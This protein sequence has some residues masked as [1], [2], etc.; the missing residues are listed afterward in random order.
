M[1]K[2]ITIG[3]I[4]QRTYQTF[5]QHFDFVM[6][7]AGSL[8][9]FGLLMNA[10]SSR[11]LTHAD[12]LTDLLISVI[13]SMLFYAKVA[14]MM[15]RLVILNESAYSGFWRWSGIELRF[16]AWLLLVVALVGGVTWWFLDLNTLLGG[17]PSSE[18]AFNGLAY[19]LIMLAITVLFA[20]LAFIFPATAAGHPVRLNQLWQSSGQRPFLLYFLVIVVPIL[21]GALLEPLPTQYLIMRLVTE[22]VAAIVVVYEVGL[23]SHL[24]D[25]MRDSPPVTDTSD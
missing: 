9:A 8:V 6:V 15:H 5:A 7:L 17:A 1:N 19:L 2:P 24:Y 21:T 16:V 12:L 25:A 4:F 11:Y 23:L 14:V 13:L 10:L 3:T 20:R 18:G 22:S